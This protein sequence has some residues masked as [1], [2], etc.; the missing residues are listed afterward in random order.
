MASRK[1]K[2][3]QVNIAAHPHPKGI[4]QELLDKASSSEGVEYGRKWF[5]KIGSVSR[6]EG[7]IIKGQFGVWKEFNSGEP[8]INKKT[9]EQKDIG[10]VVGDIPDGFGY[11]SKRF[12]FAFREID[13]QMFVQVNNDIGDT[14]Q[15]SAVEAGLAASLS[16]PAKELGIDVSVT[17]IP[18]A[19]VIER[20]YKL[21]KIKKITID[22]FIPNGDILDDEIE[23]R[24]NVRKQARV[25]REVRTLY[26][27]ENAESIELT[28]D[29][30]A[31]ME[32]AS[33]N[34][35]VDAIGT[36]DGK[37]QHLKTK[38]HP[39]IFSRTISNDDSSAGAAVALARKI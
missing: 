24:V 1:A 27:S 3:I 32:L 33:R 31:D 14:I 12:N 36:V 13:H 20:F 21:E 25:Q 6:L 2:F 28:T 26:V 4:Y 39:Q 29:I 18:E 22:V 8:V 10:E 19:D 30:R 35:S 11:P 37:R 16:A 5:A 17:V 7:G 9:L 34:G 15:P 23:R 38:D